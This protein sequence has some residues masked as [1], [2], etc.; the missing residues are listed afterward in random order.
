M[1]RGGLAM[2]TISDP[3][4]PRASRFDADRFRYGWRYVRRDLPDGGVDWDQV[5]L[6]LEDVLH[7]QMGDVQVLSRSHGNDCNYLK[8]VFEARLAG[9]PSAVVLADTGVKWDVPE[10]RHHSPDVAVILGVRQQRDWGMFEVAEEGVRPA[11]IVEVTSPASRVNDVVT[12]VDHYYRAG[13]P[14]YVIVDA[15]EA[16]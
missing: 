16:G 13:V 15:R 8:D 5:P 9:D 14:H 10:L 2:S 3:Q 1:T 11:L 7:P 4:A 6:T 12:K